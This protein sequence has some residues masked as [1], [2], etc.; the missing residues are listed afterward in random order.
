MET[1]KVV[2]VKL[3]E[4]DR[5]KISG[6]D[7]IDPS[8]IIE[9]AESIR[10]KG[11]MS[12]ITLRP[13]NGRYEIVAGDRRFLAHEHLKLKVIP[14]FIKEMDDKET[15]IYRAIE[16]LQRENLGPLEEARAYST[17]YHEGG[18]SWKELCKATGKSQG[19]IHRYLNFWKMP[20][21]FKQAVDRK[22][23]SLG[24]AEVLVGVEDPF[25]RSEWLRMAL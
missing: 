19:H 3:K 20:D 13:V 1:Q 25:L 21:D 15:I 12:P 23:V 4:I 8:K 18:M 9:L 10:E 5:P 16:N 22:G 17:M 6:R 2:Q 14:A 7:A 11:L 24:V